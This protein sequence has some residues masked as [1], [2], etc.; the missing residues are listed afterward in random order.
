MALSAGAWDGVGVRL[1]TLTNVKDG[2]GLPV[3][4]GQFVIHAT[5]VI[6]RCA[7]ECEA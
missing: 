5:G 4:Y 7:L 6:W 1:G 2:C 3:L